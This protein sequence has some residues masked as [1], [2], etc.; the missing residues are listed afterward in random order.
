MNKGKLIICGIFVGFV[1]ERA[2]NRLFIDIGIDDKDCR[3]SF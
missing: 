3:N 1:A 2:D